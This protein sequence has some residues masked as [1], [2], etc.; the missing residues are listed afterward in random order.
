MTT[1]SPPG[2][3]TAKTIAPYGLW[4]S[5]VT[6][7]A[8]FRGTSAISSPRACRRTGRAYFTESRPDG[9]NYIVELKSGA[10]SSELKDVLP[11]GYNARSRVYEYGGGPYA[12]LGGGGRLIFS[13][14]ADD[15]VSIL[16]ADS[17][18]V[19]ELVKTPKLRYGDFDAH[20]DEDGKQ[21][22]VLAVEEDHAV[23]EVP[24]K[25]GNHVV[26]I[27]TQTGE[28]KRLVS[29]SDLYMSPRF[30]HDGSKI[31]W[32]EWDFPD[33]PW[34]GVR[35]FWA[36]WSGSAGSV[37][38]IEHIA[39]D[40]AASATEPRWGPDGYL[41]YC[42]EL[43]NWRQ[44][45]RR[46]PCQAEATLI[47]INGLE[48]VEFGKATMALANNSYDVLS[49]RYLVAVY[50]KDGTSSVIKVDL[51]T[52][53]YRDVT[54]PLADVDRDG[55]ARLDDT[56]FLLVGT[57]HTTPTTLYRVNV[58]GNEN[59]MTTVRVST[60][61]SFD[62]SLFS[63]PEHIEFQSK[64]QPSRM[65]H[66]FFWPPYSP[67]FTGPEGY[68]PPLIVQSHGGPTAHTPPGLR[69]DLQYWNT[70]GYATF[71]I[72]Y[73]GSTGHGK[74]YRDSL[75]ANWGVLDVDDVAEA[76]AYLAESGRTDGSLT[77]IRGGSA[78]GYSV[79]QALC[80]YPDIFAGGV[81]LYGIS[82]VKLLLAETHKM[83]CRYVDNLMFTNDMDAKQRAKV[84]H[85]RSPV[86]HAGNITAPL[87]MLHGDEDKV[88]PISQAYTMY[89]DIKKRG[90]EVKLVKFE[91][92]GHGFRKGENLITGQTEEEEWWKKTLVRK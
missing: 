54:L 68:K 92:E 86:Y 51:N 88:V 76:V 55:I 84:M 62:S 28:V 5:E 16:D 36:D 63:T 46:Q 15:S 35:L 33:M 57:G 81:C 23:S 43:T 60:T 74:A 13:N 9:V 29:G 75:N 40:A 10:S 14:K 66:G 1:T 12:I 45:Y 73:S 49:E 22:W 91:G 69:L 39:G 11:A 90:G 83:E 52:F 79:L 21:P 7:E 67:S 20:P 58:D 2:T 32:V 24:E 65:I 87:L 41:Y 53:E 4:E 72:N 59:N 19:I 18:S 80:C 48:D 64:K 77:G 38:N 47:K 61:Q 27:N 42:H 17:G 25:V 3:S 56:S 71:A 89:D 44:I 70:R 50:L 34:S 30:S 85:D 37:S 82:E 31:C 26:A 6:K 78:G 8:V